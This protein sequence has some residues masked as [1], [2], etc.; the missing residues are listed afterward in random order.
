MKLW[1]DEITIS[2]IW[3]RRIVQCVRFSVA[4]DKK[5]HYSDALS[6]EIM[7]PSEPAVARRGY[8]KEVAIDRI[9]GS[10]S[11]RIKN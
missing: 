4:I 7:Y 10:R 5:A 3:P 9:C 8:I 2:D 1:W 11:V 6:G